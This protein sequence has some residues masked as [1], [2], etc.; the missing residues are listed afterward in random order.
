MSAIKNCYAVKMALLLFQV[1]IGNRLAVSSSSEHSASRVFPMHF[2]SS[3]S[4]E[5]EVALVFCES[6]LD[7]AFEFIAPFFHVSELD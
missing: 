2:A 4:L 6:V 3:I 1:F 5:R 7:S